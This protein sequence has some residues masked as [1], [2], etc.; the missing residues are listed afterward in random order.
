[1]NL[2]S[3][4]SSTVGR[5]KGKYELLVG[6]RTLGGLGFLLV[7]NYNF[8]WSNQIFRKME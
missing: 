2:V 6:P 5:K 4:N 8:S 3:S 7:A 1:M